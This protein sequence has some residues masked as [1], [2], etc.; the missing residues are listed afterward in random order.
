MAAET[1]E[2][3]ASVSIILQSIEVFEFEDRKCIE[4]I[5]IELSNNFPD[6]IENTL[7]VDRLA[8]V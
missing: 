7:Y 1:T 8:I 6:V 4:N 3:A 2:M 5:I